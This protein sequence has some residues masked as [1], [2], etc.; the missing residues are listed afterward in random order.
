MKFLKDFDEFVKLGIVRKQTFDKQ[1]AESLIL[2]SKN[3]LRFFEKLKDKLGF[4][5]LNPNFVVEICYD[6]LI[7]KIRAIML[8]RGYK[9]ESHEAE[10][11][12]LRI[13][14]VSESDVDFM[15]NLRYF[16]NGIKYY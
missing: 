15:N 14:G 6:V 7:Q 11:S 9:S 2:E 12:Y 10:V 3:K 8:L 13:L 4:D 16:R 5:E 1:R